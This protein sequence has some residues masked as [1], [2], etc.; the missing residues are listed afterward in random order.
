MRLSCHPNL[1]T[2]RL[3]CVTHQETK[4]HVHGLRRLLCATS[5]IKALELDHHAFNC[6]HMKHL[7]GTLSAYKRLTKLSITRFAIAESAGRLFEQYMRMYDPA[8]S[9]RKLHIS[10]TRI[11]CG[12][13]SF[14]LFLAGS[15]LELPRRQES[16]IGSSLHVLRL[17]NVNEDTFF[18]FSSSTFLKP[19][20]LRSLRQDGV[21]DD[22]Q[23]SPRTRNR[24]VNVT[25]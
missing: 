4:F 19:H 17:L 6:N 25:S 21:G 2:L 24:T 23:N 14:S 3:C 16:S 9:L 1:R 15:F 7:L 10:I 20:R 22:A 12:P 11:W 18:G 13:H 8:N 5:S